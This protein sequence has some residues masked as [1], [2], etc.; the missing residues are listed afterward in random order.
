MFPL[1]MY[2]L[3]LMAS[4]FTIFLTLSQFL[5]VLPVLTIAIIIGDKYTTTTYQQFSFL[6]G[7]GTM[8]VEENKAIAHRIVEEFLNTG[9]LDAV[10]RFFATDFINHNPARGITNDREGIK[11]YIASLYTAFPD[12]NTTID[13]LI[14]EGDKVVCRVTTSGTHRGDLEGIP[15]TGKRMSVTNITIFRIANGKVFE[16]WNVS[17]QLGILQQ[18]GVIPST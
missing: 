5:Y 16:R 12:L 1:Y 4:T 2:G 9:D 7:V 14:A 3:L 8:S 6:K 15:P 10:D 17:D 13:D 18:L 11:H